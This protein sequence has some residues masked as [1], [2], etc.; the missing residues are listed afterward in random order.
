M[1]LSDP[2]QEDRSTLS[3]L[4]RATRTWGEERRAFRGVDSQLLALYDHVVREFHWRAWPWRGTAVAVRVHGSA[5]PFF[6]RVGSSDFMVLREL[7]GSLEYEP[8]LERTE[9]VKVVVDLGSNIGVSIR[10]FA[11]RYPEAVVVGVEPD[12]GNLAMARRNLAAARLW[13]R[14]RL[15]R[16]CVAAREG[17]VHF[18]CSGLPW[19]FRVVDRAGPGTVDVEAL[20][21]ERILDETIADGEID[22]LKCDVEGAEEEIFYDCRAWIR[23]VRTMI[24]EIHPGSYT[25]ERFFEDLQRAGYPVGATKVI[26]A[27]HNVLLVVT[28]AGD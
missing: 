11:E 27:G 25:F 13:S 20:P 17:S 19:A 6:A 8:A 12:D 22:L 21:V 10:L 1:T 15:V 26:R 24:V 16:A 3:R 5:R 18:Y 28:R 4:W 7:F 2:K 14:V 23:R 9:D